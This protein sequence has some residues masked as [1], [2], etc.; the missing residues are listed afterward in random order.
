MW[1]EFEY[2]HPTVQWEVYDQKP[3]HVQAGW[4]YF[5]LYENIYQRIRKPQIVG[6]GFDIYCLFLMRNFI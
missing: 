4:L 5:H 6:A 3:I 1:E 2:K